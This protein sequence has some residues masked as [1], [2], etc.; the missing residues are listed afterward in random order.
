MKKRS[1]KRFSGFTLIELLVV[2]LIIGILAAI[3][4]PQYKIA[5]VKSKTA[6]IMPFLKNVVEGIDLYFLENGTLPSSFEDLYVE[7]PGEC[8]LKV[9]QI[10]IIPCGNDWQFNQQRGEYGFIL[11]T[12]CPG[13][14]DGYW[15]CV[16]SRD[17]QLAAYAH[18]G[19]QNAAGTRPLG[20]M[21]CEK[22]TDFG[23][24]ICNQLLASKVV[25]VVF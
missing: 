7:I 6:T 4:L 24:K 25:S 19:V 2:V 22:F 21:A 13:K 10:E 16:H 11:G 5:V 20:G 23:A 17:F 8:S 15:K 3:A 12:Y 14:N 1:I 18:N 9:D